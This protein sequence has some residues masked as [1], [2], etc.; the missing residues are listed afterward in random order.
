MIDG[1]NRMS[2]HFRH[3]KYRNFLPSERLNKNTLPPNLVP[4][5]QTMYEKIEELKKLKEEVLKKEENEHSKIAHLTQ[6]MN[7]V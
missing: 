1:A 4:Q 6:Q 5:M 2:E 7:H 3:E